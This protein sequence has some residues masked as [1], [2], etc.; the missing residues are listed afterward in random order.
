M[1]A[2]GKR[3]STNTPSTITRPY[4]RGRQRQRQ[5]ITN[6]SRV[7]TSADFYVQSEA[8][9]PLPSQYP[10][11]LFLTSPPPP[12]PR[13][14]PHSTPF[15]PLP[16]PNNYNWTF[17]GYGL[18]Y[19]A[20]RPVPFSEKF[21]GYN[22]GHIHS[23]F[24]V[25]TCLFRLY[26]ILGDRQVFSN[27]HLAHYQELFDSFSS[28]PPEGASVSLSPIGIIE[29]E[30]YIEYT[31]GSGFDGELPEFHGHFSDGIALVPAFCPSC[32]FDEKLPMYTRM[33]Q[34]V[35]PFYLPFAHFSSVALDSVT[36]SILWSI[37]ITFIG[38]F[39]PNPKIYVLSPP[40]VTTV[41]PNKNL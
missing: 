17:P 37:S 13:T 2:M 26:D 12:P 19:G 25:L 11:Q 5:R 10:L 1:T 14:S 8:Q 38:R 34:L 3:Q 24:E 32:V 16:P 6:L 30:K 18:R 28:R 35:I 22:F 29:T 40:A 21:L 9:A 36:S 31:A 7:I 41:S 33:H 27:H 20:A 39:L 15:P 23:L 4:S